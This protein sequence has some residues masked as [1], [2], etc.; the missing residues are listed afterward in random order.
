[1]VPTP[2]EPYSGYQLHQDGSTARLKRSSAEA[3]PCDHTDL[4]LPLRSSP[5]RCANGCAFS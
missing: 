2:P 5:M 4:P 3:L 1:M